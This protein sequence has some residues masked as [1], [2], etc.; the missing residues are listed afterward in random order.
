MRGAGVQAIASSW[1]E[2]ATIARL[3]AGG[4]AGF[5]VRS[6]RRLRC[7]SRIPDP[8]DGLRGFRPSA[9][10][11]PTFVACVQWGQAALRKLCWVRRKVS[12][13]SLIGTDRRDESDPMTREDS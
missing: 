11:S 4:K 10:F 7:H 9:N 13:A 1:K 8:Q 12:K 2:F 3:P 6:S 5:R